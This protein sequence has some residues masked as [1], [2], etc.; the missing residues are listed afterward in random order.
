MIGQLRAYS[1]ALTVAIAGGVFVL[2]VSTFYEP[3]ALLSLGLLPFAVFV[4]FDAQRRG[5]DG[6]PWGF[7]ALVTAGFGL[8]VYGIVRALDAKKGITILTL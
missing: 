7:L 1:H 6:R 3:Y 2:A 4:A 8:L 5:R